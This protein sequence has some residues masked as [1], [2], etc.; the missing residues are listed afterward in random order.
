MSAAASQ[1]RPNT[2][3]ALWQLV[4]FQ[5][6][7]FA[8]DA[9]LQ[10]PR[11]LAFLIPGL[12]I[13]EAF[14]LLSRDMRITAGLWTLL[15]LLVGSGVLRVTMIYISALM[16]ITLQNVNAALLRTNLLRRILQLPGARAL[17][18]SPGETITR[19]GG[20]VNEIATFVSEALQ[21]FGMACY[22][23]VA[24]AIMAGVD[25]L[26]TVAVAIP[27]VAVT[28]IT[29]LGT[30]RIQGYRRDTR[31]AT[32]RLYAF[33]A[34]TFSAVQAVQVAGAEQPVLRQFDRLGDVRR[35][36]VLKE[37]FFGEMVLNSLSDSV[38]NLNAGIILL[39]IARSFQTGQFTLGDFALFI[40]FLTRVTDFT[41]NLGRTYARYKQTDVSFDRLFRLMQPEQRPAC[42]PDQLLE[43]RPVHLRAPMP[44]APSLP[45]SEKP[46][47]DVLREL[48]V[49]GLRY[50]FPG[51]ERGIEAIDLTLRRGEFVVITGRIGAG[52]TTLLRALLGLLPKDA[53]EIEWN[54]QRVADPAAF[55]APPRAAYTSQ[56]PRL[57]SDSLRDNILLGWPADGAAISDAIRSAVMERDLEGLERR[58]DTM[59]G[60]RGVKLS[61]G[62]IQRAAAARMFVRD[63]ELLV[64][65]SLSSALDVETE[66]L[67]WDRI[68]ERS[69]NATCLVVSHRAAALRRAD[70]ILVLKDG[71]IDAQGRLDELLRNSEEMR[72]LWRAQAST[73][74]DEGTRRRGDAEGP[75]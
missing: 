6:G 58:F 19:I 39:L 61:G 68:V 69:A 35:K 48:S 31:R 21:L 34:E 43:H 5:R 75:V 9:L 38:T 42:A 17:P 74:E 66:G 29:S 73:V 22:A 3:R 15:G 63:A 67:L 20:D 62:Q 24:F 23:G 37:R 8:L 41:F 32:G 12:I 33:I 52:K 46:G 49:R 25:P 56:V 27:L 2:L 71:R 40:S 53:G 45:A 18:Y 13:R 64:F 65:D 57:F 10:I 70:H 50:R 28:L 36:A 51:T 11:Q 47:G 26:V 59:I 30:L 72:H 7:L 54:G 16:D 14:N 1:P 4:T 55:F 44:E 60:P